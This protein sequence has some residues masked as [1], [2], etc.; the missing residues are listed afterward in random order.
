MFLR[1]YVERFFDIVIRLFVHPRRQVL[2]SSF[3][4]QYTC[5]P[6][7]I[8]LKLH[9]MYPDVRILWTSSEKSRE[10]SLPNYIETVRFG[11]FQY[12]F[13]K[14]SSLVVVD[15][16][17]GL[18]LVIEDGRIP[19]Y[20]RLL[21]N[22]KQLNLSTW[23]GT[24]LK[25]IGINIG[26]SSDR[27]AVFST[28]DLL[29]AGCRYTKEI[30][31][32]A[33]LNSVP[34]YAIGTPRNDILIESSHNRIEDLKRKLGIPPLKRV[35]LFAPTYRDSIEDSGLRQLREIDVDL[36]LDTLKSKFGGDWVL[37]VRVHQMVQ[38]HYDSIYKSQFCSDQRVVDGNI[39]DDMAEYLLV[40]DVLL[41]DYS[42]S[43]FDFSLTGK[44]CFLFT[45]DEE[46]YA[47]E[48]GFYL[49]L[50]ELPFPRASSF[51]GLMDMIDRFSTDIYLDHLSSF[52]SYL[53]NV[54]DGKAS[55]KIVNILKVYIDSKDLKETLKYAKDIEFNS[56]RQY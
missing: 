41:S 53:G 30:L 19:W 20:Y 7:Y 29:I 36:L 26:E 32:K 50:D 22:Y 3:Q 31:E 35:I 16:G 47:T 55:E 27:L 37:V 34:V 48:R 52:L 14:H 15:N 13:Q 42:G 1:R 8:S 6:K 23:H 40:T 11:S 51:S 44:P 28:S 10:H 9:E 54:E 17:A 33:F 56:E 46:K 5:N 38:Q 4:G 25:K 2:F 21:K 18:N 49:N 39:G 12:Y 43:I 24:P 45:Q